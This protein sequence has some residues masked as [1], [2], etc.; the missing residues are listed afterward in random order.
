MEKKAINR[1]FQ[2]VSRQDQDSFN[3]RE[4]F[5]TFLTGHGWELSNNPSLV[6]A[7]GGDGTMLQAFQKH[8]SPTTLFVGVHTGNLGFY[9]DW[10]KNELDELLSKIIHE[11]PE[12][13]HYPLLEVQLHKHTTDTSST[14]QN[15]DTYLAL[16]EFVI[17]S[18]R[19]ATLHVDYNINKGRE[20]RYVGDGLII[21][22]PSGSTGYNHSAYGAI[23]H[24]SLEA[25]QLTEMEAINSIKNRSFNRSLIL[26]KHHSIEITL[27]PE[28][29]SIDK[30]AFGLDCKKLEVTDVNKI[31]LKVAKQK[32]A[33]ARYRPFPFFE[34]VDDK[35][36][37]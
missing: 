17:A 18:E 34:R 19:F 5:M 14:K 29:T 7:I 6:I 15:I 26:P 25:M 35:F 16:N 24:P 22:T 8:Y 37:G 3:L 2:I 23:V 32:I 21:S 13:I 1:M 36:L 10:Q 30:I 12:V 28:L 11:Q 9:N 27:L 31:T 20:H 4:K 33:F